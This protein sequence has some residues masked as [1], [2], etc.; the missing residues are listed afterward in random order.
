MTDNT[1][2]TSS[3]SGSTLTIEDIYEA[4]E[5]MPDP[6][7]TNYACSPRILEKIKEEYEG[8]YTELDANHIMIKGVMIKAHLM[9]P[10]DY[11]I[12]LDELERQIMPQ[13]K[14]LKG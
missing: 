13:F 14:Y 10:D 3:F 11:M 9:V 5:K 6:I 8:E 12:D 1:G 7:S 2:T 4:M